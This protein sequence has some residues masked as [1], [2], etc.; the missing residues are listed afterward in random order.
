MTDAGTDC[1][2][3]PQT[4]SRKETAREG[5]GKKEKRETG[6]KSDSL[7]HGIFLASCGIADAPFL[8]LSCIVNPCFHKMLILNLLITLV[9]L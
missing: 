8:Y 7:S 2:P 9:W 5:E 3:S 1:I 6:N 4:Q